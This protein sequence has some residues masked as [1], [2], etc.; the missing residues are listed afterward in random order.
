MDQQPARPPGS[1]RRAGR[2]L[3]AVAVVVAVTVVALGGGESSVPTPLVPVSLTDPAPPTDVVVTPADRALA[4]SWS[5]SREPGVLGYRVWVDGAPGPITQTTSATL[6]GLVNGRSYVVTV[7]SGTQQ[8]GTTYEGTT[9]SSPVTGVPRDSVAPARP[10]GVTAVGGDGQV[11]V[12]WTA[13]TVAYD[14]DGYRVLR[15]GVAVSGLIGG[16]A[17]TSWTDTGLA[18]DTTYGYTVQTHDTSGNWS[19]PSSPAVRATPTDSTAPAVPT[20]LTATRGDGEVALV[21]AADPDADLALYRLF[22]DGVQVAEVTGTGH[23]DRGLTNDRPYAYTLVAVDGHGN[24]SEP[25]DPAV[26]TPTD[27]TPPAVPVDV[28]AS[29]GDGQAVVRWSPVPD[30][31]LAG[32]RVLSGDGTV[33]ADV[34]APVAEVVVPGLEDDV[35]QVLTVV[36]VDAAGNVSAR[37]TAVRVTPVAR[38][39]PALG[40]GEGGGLAVGGDGRFVVVGTRARLEPADTNSAH[41]LH[42]LDRAAGTARR[43]APLPAGATA[44]DSTNAGAPAVSDDGRYV[45][46]ATTSALV[47]ADTN[48]AADVYRLDTRD[49]SWALVSVPADGKAST[50]PGTVLHTGP[51]VHA[52]S[53]TVVVSADGDLVV[54][55]STRADLGP[56]DTNGVV[57]VYAKRMSTGAVTR[58]STTAAGAD[59]P[60]TALG[61][62]LA[63]TPD[64]RFALFPASSSS[65]VVA[66]Y[67]KTLSGAGAGEALVVSTV[68][69]AGRATE[70]AVFRDAGDID[71]SDDGRYVA[72][73]TAAKLGTTTPTASWTT[74]L[75]Y[76]VHTA[77]GSVVPLGDGQRTAWEHQVALDPT[78]R[79]G[80]FATVAPAVAGDGNGHTDHFRRDLDG[81]VVGPLRLV[82]ADAAGAATGGV[83]G[84]I[85]A[86]EYGRLVAVTG[87]RVLVTTSQALLPADTNRLRDLYAKDL[88]SGAVRSVVG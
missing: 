17:S 86:A 29:A 47:A 28:V 68:P 39:V 73:V 53:P 74:G 63:L 49:G 1:R 10:T 60:R 56:R 55:Y 11:R 33:L 5:P 72:L 77:T 7:R 59:L 79:Y 62:A 26:A 21:W 19:V 52:T 70:F 65:G 13:D 54:F 41:E 25:A 15:D 35:E 12:G 14:A 85:A 23:V 58:V 87:D 8:A 9:A 37:S 75:A 50:V 38:P 30:A 16:R 3:R 46:L 88:A 57:D 82:T 45:A 18:N 4:V 31:D 27:L 40:A 51:S 32:Y 61:P 48:R 22:R 24:A 81:G 44:A 76:R 69:V 43:I 80:F 42:L 78:G 2:G 64:G 84:S 71:L 6:S 83:T 67:R 34:P 66:L 36:A 20:G